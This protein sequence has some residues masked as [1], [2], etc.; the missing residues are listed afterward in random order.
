MTDRTEV[1]MADHSGEPGA[2]QRQTADAFGFKWAR[3][4][5]Y[6]SEAMKRNHLAWMVERY[7]GGDAAAIDAMLAGGRKTILDAGCGAAYSALLLFGERLARHDYIGVDISESVAVAEQRFKELNLPGRFIQADL[8]RVPLPD[9]SA[10][11]IFSEGVLHH[12]DSVRGAI[13]ALTP[14][15][16]RG[17]RML[18]YVYRKKGP[19]REFCD[20]HIRREIEPLDNE[21]A[22]EALKPLT[23]LGMA[24]GELNVTVD[25]P[26]DVPLLGIPKG[27]VNL[28]RLFYW[29]V[30][31]AF[32]RPDMTLEE[33]NHVNF[34]WY[35]PL[36]CIR[37]TPEE[38]RAYC[39]EAGLDIERMDVQ[40]AGITVV[41]R[42]A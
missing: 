10:D 39:A 30:C 38:I 15:L 22:W 27:P 31:K 42:R 41:A 29:H 19:L 16:R 13:L 32:Y 34:D 23:R 25:V 8:M 35:R 40:E 3:R 33:M 9:A 20:D 26:E 14:K 37:S 2:N 1:A 18:F 21:A 11:L 4:D 36:N 28:Q 17:G 5:T 24:L 7:L 12:T 6:E